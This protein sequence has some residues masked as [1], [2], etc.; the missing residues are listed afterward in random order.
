MD[1]L[2]KAKQEN[3][4]DEAYTNDLVA[5]SQIEAHA[6]KLFNAADQQ[7]KLV[8]T[9]NDFDRSFCLVVVVSRIP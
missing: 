9:A 3:H 2:E 8:V 1:M 4:D 5:Q 7:D 6:L